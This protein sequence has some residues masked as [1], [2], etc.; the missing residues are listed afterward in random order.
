MLSSLSNINLFSMSYFIECSQLQMMSKIVHLY[1]KPLFLYYFLLITT[2]TKNMFVNSQQLLLIILFIC[3][4]ITL[5]KIQ[6]DLFI[7]FYSFFY[8]FIFIPSRSWQ[9]N[10]ALDSKLIFIIYSSRTRLH[11]RI[12]KQNSKVDHAKTL[13]Y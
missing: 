10:Q 4:V 3:E 12:I 9:D 11:R 7:S 8:S 2:M 5:H 1:V 6:Y 13:F